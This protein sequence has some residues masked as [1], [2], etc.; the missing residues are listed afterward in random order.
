MWIN[1]IDNNT[2]WGDHQAVPLRHLGRYYSQIWWTLADVVADGG[3][4]VPASFESR[5][6]DA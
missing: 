3:C 1:D 4:H 2:L 6:P 5:S